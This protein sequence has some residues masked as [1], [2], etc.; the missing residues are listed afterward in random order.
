[1][2]IV[3]LKPGILDTIQDQGRHGYARWGVNPSGV[4][5]TYASRIANALV[6]NDLRDAVLEMH[7]P[8]SSF[9]FEDDALVAITG[10]DFDATLDG[11]SIPLWKPVHI[12]KNSILQFARRRWGSRCYLAVAGGLDLELWLE[13]RSTNLIANAGG[14]KGRALRKGDRILAC[15]QSDFIPKHIARNTVLPWSVNYHSTYATNQSISF[16]QGNEWPWLSRTSEASFESTSFSIETKSDRMACYLR[17]EPMSITRPADMISS[18]VTF[19]TMQVLPDGQVVVLMAD[20]QTTGGYPRIGHVISAHHP[21]LAQ[22]SP[23]EMFT[24]KKVSVET[25]E[26][27]L[28]AMEEN[29]MVLKAGCLKN[30]QNFYAER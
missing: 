21:V 3:V 20:H 4:M 13:S 17:H 5:D 18:G 16:V 7:F 23:G 10:A 22:H 8:A 6:G 24:F 28:M 29:I 11:M 26:Q 2:T 15:P 25:A 1:M 19:G 9:R 27:M 30:L 12:R 14:Y